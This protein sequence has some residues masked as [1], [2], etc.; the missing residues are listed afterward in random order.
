MN[1]AFAL[2][3]PGITS[4]RST[5]Q[6]SEMAGYILTF[7]LKRAELTR[8]AMETFGA[9]IQYVDDAIEA[10]SLSDGRRRQLA[11]PKRRD[12]YE[13]WQRDELVK[14]RRSHDARELRKIEEAVRTEVLEELGDTDVV[15]FDLLLMARVNVLLSAKHDLTRN[16]FLRRRKASRADSG[17]RAAT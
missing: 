11:L 7:A 4:R 2:L 16:E 10:K 5:A 15:G 3:T 17:R 1:K 14:I 8:F 13:D 6:G 12:S 9:V